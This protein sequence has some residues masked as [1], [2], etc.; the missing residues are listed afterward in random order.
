LKSKRVELVETIKDEEFMFF[1]QDIEVKQDRKLKIKKIISY[2][3]SQECSKIL[4]ENEIVKTKDYL[5]NLYKFETNRKFISNRYISLFVMIE[6]FEKQIRIS[7]F[8]M[9][10]DRDFGLEIV[11]DIF[12][13]EC[14]ENDNP[15][16]NLCLKGCDVDICLAEIA[17]IEDYVAK[18]KA[19]LHNLK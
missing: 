17:Y 2:I 19:L 7:G 3:D 14:W 16:I 8:V 1:N 13:Y 15:K 11:D 9:L 18:F 12:H 10:S 6:E 4:L 5:G